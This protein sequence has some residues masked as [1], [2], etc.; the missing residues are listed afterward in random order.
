[1]NTA[2]KLL[3]ITQRGNKK[4]LVLIK[5]LQKLKLLS[6]KKRC[7]L[8]ERKMKMRKGGN[9]RD[10]YRWVCRRHNRFM[11]KSIRDG[12]IFSGSRSSLT[13]WM[14]FMHRFAQGLRLRQVDLIEEGVCGSSRTLSK[15][16]K[17]LRRVCVQAVKHLKR[18]GEMRI[19]GRHGFVVIDESKFCHK[20]KYARGRFG[21]TWRR[22]G[23]VFGL[24]E[25]NQRRRRP[26]LKFVRRR[27][28]ERLLPI[29]QRY[30][31]P[32]STILSDSWRSYC[33]LRQ[34]GY[35]HYQVNHQRFFV[36]PATGA[37]TQHIERSWRTFK[38][39]VYRFRGNMTEKSLRE[40]LHFIEWN[41]WLGRQHRN[42][43]LGRLFKDIRAIHPVQ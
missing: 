4:K 28:S 9:T 8:C 14:M 30:V 2:E 22:R 12:S 31:R 38:Q 6:K 41:Y 15:M 19:G 5:W 29:I 21:A 10:G 42:G 39:E 23:W 37:H 36:H 25:V 26:V 1:M 18:R 24:L 17:T 34:H 11:S 27:N 16:S 33:R 43:P 3:N 13:S 7:S 20:R 32:A 35:I 40:I